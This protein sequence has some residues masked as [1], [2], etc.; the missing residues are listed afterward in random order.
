MESYIEPKQPGLFD[1]SERLEEPH[2]MGDP[3][4]R[5]D[6]VIDWSVFEPVMGLIPRAD[7]KGPGGRPGFPPLLMFKVWVIGHL[8]NLSDA[9]LEFQITARHSFKRFLGITNADKSPDQKHYGYRNHV[10]VDSKS[11]LIV[12][13]KVTDASVHDSQALDALLEEGDPTTYVDSAYTGPACEAAFEGKRVTGKVIDRAYRNKPLTARQRK[14]NRAK[15]RI[16]I[17]GTQN[18]AKRRFLE[19]PPNTGSG[20]SARM[21]ISGCSPRSTR[22]G[23]CSD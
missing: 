13:F 9:Q 12:K 6:A 5:L 4:A 20:R 16:R 14:S 7:P 10:K 21:P 8:Y 11:K 15:S 23:S 18:Y 1:T 17:W 2:K 19:V 3:L 22:W